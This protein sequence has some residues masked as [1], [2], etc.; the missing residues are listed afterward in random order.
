M[1]QVRYIEALKSDVLAHFGRTLDA[2]TDYDMLSVAIEKSTGEVISVSTLKRIFGYKGQSTIPRPSTLSVLAR[3]VGS[4]GWSDYCQRVDARGCEDV[5]VVSP[6]RKRTKWWYVAV[7]LLALGVVAA[8]VI[9]NFP[10]KSKSPL[11]SASGTLPKVESI[12]EQVEPQ[13]NKEQQRREEIKQF[14]VQRSQAMC[15]RVR[16]SRGDMHIKEYAKVIDEAYFPFVFDTLATSLRQMCNESFEPDKAELYYTEIFSL[17]RDM[18]AN[19]RIEVSNELVE[20]VYGASYTNEA[21][22]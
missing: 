11:Q 15:K 6:T 22:N 9:I 1:E 16:A 18:C 21:G 19:I 4:V 20:A 12:N 8:V 10:D 7:A 2:P 5:E 13:V 14:W 17:C 3:Y